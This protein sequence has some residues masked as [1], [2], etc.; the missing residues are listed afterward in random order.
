MKIIIF[1]V[2]FIL[3]LIIT[4]PYD[5]YKKY[6]LL[7]QNIDKHNNIIS[8]IKQGTTIYYILIFVK[9]KDILLY[10]IIIILLDF[11]TIDIFTLS[12]YYHLSRSIF[13]IT[14]C[15][16]FIYEIMY[17]IINLTYRVE[18]NINNENV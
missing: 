13:Y 5:E 9:Y 3:F 12:F 16:I 4:F 2:L 8:T 10:D 11:V 18:H 7:C 6:P 17:V 15:S 1:N 14:S